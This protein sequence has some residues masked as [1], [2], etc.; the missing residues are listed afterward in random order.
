MPA[1]FSADTAGAGLSVLMILVKAT[2]ILLAALAVTRTMERGSAIARHLVWFV[3]LGSLLLIPALSSW[4][5]IRLA[6]LPALT[7]YETGAA[8]AMSQTVL[9]FLNAQ[10]S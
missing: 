4:T 8:P 3:S 10:S 5:P 9:P 6:I 1:I 2:L 7:H